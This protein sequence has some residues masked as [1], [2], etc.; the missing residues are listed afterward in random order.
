MWPLY[1]NKSL[2]FDSPY[3]HFAFAVFPLAKSRLTATVSSGDKPI[4]FVKPD[5]S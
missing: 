2:P 5:L 3:T 4:L 1:S